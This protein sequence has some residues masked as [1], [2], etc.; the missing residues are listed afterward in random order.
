MFHRGPA[1]QVP[2]STRI[3]A[4]PVFKNKQLRTIGNRGWLWR[5]PFFLKSDR[6]ITAGWAGKGVRSSPSWGKRLP[7]VNSESLGISPT[8]GCPLFSNGNKKSR[9]NVVL[10]DLEV[11]ARSHSGSRIAVD[12]DVCGHKRFPFWGTPRLNAHPR[13]PLPQPP[14]PSA[15]RPTTLGSA[16]FSRRLS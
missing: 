10:K 13:L 7:W 15:P 12:S 2:A 5:K 4:H 9:E 16:P 11:T 3:P 1:A 14:A 8:L 6:L